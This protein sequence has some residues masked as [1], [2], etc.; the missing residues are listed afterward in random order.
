MS[1]IYFESAYVG[2]NF[3][4]DIIS[5]LKF[6]IEFLS[7]LCTIKK[8][9]NEKYLNDLK[10]CKLILDMVNNPDFTE[11]KNIPYFKE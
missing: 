9:N 7:R 10:K 5:I 6:F 11:K 2:I 1:P 4:L 3:Q 8:M